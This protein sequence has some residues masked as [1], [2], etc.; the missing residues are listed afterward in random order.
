MTVLRAFAARF[1]A[2]KRSETEV[3]QS[4]REPLFPLLMEEGLTIVI[5]AAGASS[6]MRGRD[7]LLM[8]VGG[9]P[10]L[11]RQVRAAL[12]T[13]YP[14]IVALPAAHQARHRMV[15][16]LPVRIADVRD[17]AAGMGTSI[18]QGVRLAGSGRIMIVPADM[19]NLG[20]SELSALIDAASAAPLQIWRGMD[21]AGTPGHPVI[22]PSAFYDR[23][24]CLSGDDGAR[25]VLKDEHV[26]LAAL[27][28]DTAVLDLDTPEAWD[29]FR[30]N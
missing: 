12:G 16:D 24:T 7:K 2:P 19:P 1:L 23:L 14:V 5:P 21:A 20:T 29:A 3:L 27:P 6:R 9:E 18:A 8:D 22:F 10:L 30:Q 28:G 13:G 25:T 26:M 17:A 15:A 4:G 11:R